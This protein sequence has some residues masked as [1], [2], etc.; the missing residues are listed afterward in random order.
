MSIMDRRL[1]DLKVLWDPNVPAEVE[2]ARK[3]FDECLKKGFQAFRV[4]RKGDKDEI[5]KTFDP[6]AEAIIMSL[7]VAGG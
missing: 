5:I 1:G 6:K 7:F 3:Q 4:N 2:I